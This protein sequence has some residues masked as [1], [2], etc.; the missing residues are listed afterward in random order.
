MQSVYIFGKSVDFRNFSLCFQ[1]KAAG[2][3]AK[4]QQLFV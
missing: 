2:F 3:Q 1:K 4:F